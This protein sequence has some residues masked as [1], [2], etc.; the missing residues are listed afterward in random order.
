MCAFCR[1]MRNNGDG[2]YRMIFPASY[3]YLV[4]PQVIFIDLINV[5]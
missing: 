1:E 5:L 2:L 3:L 4:L